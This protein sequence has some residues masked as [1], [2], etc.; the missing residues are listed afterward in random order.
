MRNL[1]GLL[2]GPLRPTPAF[3]GLTNIG[4]RIPTPPVFAA[5]QPGMPAPPTPIQPPR[6]P[7]LL[8]RVLG[9]LMPGND[10]YAGLLSDEDRSAARRTGLLS[11]G[12][13]LLQAS[14]ER[15]QGQGTSLAQALGSGVLAGQQAYQGQLTNAANFRA[16]QDAR[17]AQQEQRQAAADLSRKRQEQI[18]AELA[19]ARR[20]QEEALGR[21]Q[22]VEQMTQGGKV[23]ADN[24]DGLISEALASGDSASLN[25]LMA[26]RGQLTKP[27]QFDYRDD[28]TGRIYQF[29]AQGRQTGVF[30]QPRPQRPAG[31]GAGGDG[32]STGD[33]RLNGARQSLRKEFLDDVKPARLAVSSANNV[34][35][36]LGEAT[37]NGGF[38]TAAT[39][40]AA[41]TALDPS[42]VV[43]EGELAFLQS[44]QGLRQQ[45]Q[46]MLSKAGPE[47]VRLTPQMARQLQNVMAR[48]R[49]LAEQTVNEARQDKLTTA[50]ALGIPMSEQMFT[51]TLPNA[52]TTPSGAT[53]RVPKNESRPSSA[54]AGLLTPAPAPGAGSPAR[55]ASG[56]ASKVRGV[57]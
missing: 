32:Y 34:L 12:A 14:G 54:P 22:R 52:P 51:L 6:A 43:R 18:D 46:Q 57:L 49:Q 11:L 23:T 21:R 42:S 7:G 15:P 47:G 48:R 38:A 53:T 55:R 9:G 24:I 50:G 19:D 36:N 10:S 39:M 33:A 5:T 29:D 2:G 37:R 20:K 40:Y 25:S 31:D 27:A 45:L 13:T 3:G 8:D 28:G 35:S 56:G 41:V 16:A 44:Q 26:I 4:Q 30:G 1:M 17:E